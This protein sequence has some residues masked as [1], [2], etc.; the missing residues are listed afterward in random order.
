MM[1]QEA[2]DKYEL[3]HE[4]ADARHK[5]V[6]LMRENDYLHQELDVSTQ[7]RK[8]LSHELRCVRR[9]FDSMGKRFQAIGKLSMKREES[10]GDENTMA[11]GHA[12]GTKVVDKNSDVQSELE[13][14][15]ERNAQLERTNVLL[16][17]RNAM[18]REEINKRT[19]AM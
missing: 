15:C 8:R 5:H 7:H 1:T 6:A 19:T 4:L 13:R 16:L 17:H 2:K 9:E 11:Q 10:L 14:L 3:S 12:Q 18:L